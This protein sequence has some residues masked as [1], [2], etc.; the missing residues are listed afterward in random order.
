MDSGTAIYVEGGKLRKVAETGAPPGTM[1]TVKQLFFN[2]PARRRFLKTI[3][4]EMGHIADTISGM[5]LGWP[6]VQFQLHHNGKIVKSWPAVSD[7][8]ARVSDVLGKN[9]ANFLYPV[10]STDNKI[11]IAGW[12]CDSKVTR[13][14]SR[15]I[16]IFVNGRAVRS[17][18]VQ[19]GLFEGYSGRLM[20]GQFPLAVLMITVPYDRVDVNVHPTKNEIRFAEQNKIHDLVKYAVLQA[21]K[22]SDGPKW[23]VGASISEKKFAAR[24]DGA[25]IS[26]TRY[27]FNETEHTIETAHIPS[28]HL[29]HDLNS[30]DTFKNRHS[31][32]ENQTPL[33]EKKP[34][35]DLKLIGQLHQTYILC[36]SEEGLVLIDQHAAH[37]RIRYEQLKASL[38]RSKKEAQQLVVSETIDV[39]FSEADI[40]MKLIP[41]LRDIGLGIEPFGG[42]TFVVKSVPTL[43]EGKA[44]KSV[45]MEMVEKAAEVGIVHNLEKALEECLIVMACHKTVRAHQSLSEKEITTLLTQLD[46]CENPS[47]CPH[48][49]PIWIAW[50]WRSLEKSFHRIV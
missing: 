46:D 37:E 49:R 1:V 27:A 5:A 8:K 17:R 42:K 29:I 35:G 6:G 33:W 11:S 19:H 41:R 26:E 14:T 12:I 7:P 4:T 20:K 3:N 38:N 30:E 48:G 18:L 31:K 40:L 2:T 9:I 13:H 15:G 25:G 34:F 44:I 47:H 10:K 16:Y 36:E 28:E 24:P 50:S 45:I 23:G 32:I 22:V 39:S 21:L 43:I